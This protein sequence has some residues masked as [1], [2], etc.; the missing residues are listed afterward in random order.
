[1]RL[2]TARTVEH[3]ANEHADARQALADWVA[4][5]QAARWTSPDD[6][7]R[8]LPGT[9]PIGGKRLIFNILNNR[10]RLVCDVNFADEKYNGII[11]IQFIGTHAEYD[12][13]DATTV[14]LPPKLT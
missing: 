3:F 7:L 14:T 13:I 6:A 4:V 5:V 10:Y 2:V 11:R 1:M 9:R 8:S 12:R